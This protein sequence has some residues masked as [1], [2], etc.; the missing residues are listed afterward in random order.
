MS[1]KYF[2]AIFIHFVIPLIGIVLFLKVKKNIQKKNI[3]SPPLK[4]V[5]FLF[6]T[7]GGLVIVLLTSLFW[8]WSGLASLGVFF[9][10]LIAP[11]VMLILVFKFKNKRNR[12]VYH[13]QVF[14]FS[15]LYFL[16][17]PILL[18]ITYFFS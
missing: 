6:F 5:F 3:D 9:L 2:I 11:I 7:Y 10:E 1:Y 12:S 4:E 14:Y 8:V 16:I 15:L 18:F 17:A 13:K